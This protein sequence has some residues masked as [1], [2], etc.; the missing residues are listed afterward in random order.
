MRYILLFILICLPLKKFAQNNEINC[1]SMVSEFL[2]KGGYTV[3]KAPEVKIGLD[4][5]WSIINFPNTLKKNDQFVTI[6]LLTIIDTIGNPICTKILRGL[7]EE[8]DLKAL[9]T[10]TSLNFT[11]AYLRNKAITLLTTI[12]VRIKVDFIKDESYFYGEWQQSEIV[13]VEDS[14]Y[15]NKKTIYPDSLIYGGAK[16]TFLSDSLFQYAL[17]NKVV[18][19]KYWIDIKNRVLYMSRVDHPGFDRYEVFYLNGKLI[20]RSKTGRNKLLFK[21][22]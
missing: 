10:V 4:S 1:D 3:D 11:P 15:L 5:L 8:L 9:H 16:I 18:E 21:V 17:N 13:Q 12:P 6:Y 14:H 7:T 22:N 2:S 19:G 20:L